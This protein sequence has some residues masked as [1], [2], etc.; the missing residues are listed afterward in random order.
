MKFIPQAVE[1]LKRYS[2]VL[3]LF[4]AMIIFFDLL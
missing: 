3:D 1:W 2:V 4:A